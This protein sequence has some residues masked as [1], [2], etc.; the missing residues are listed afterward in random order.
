MLS[1]KL[2]NEV[3][4]PLK[5][6]IKPR[7]E[8]AVRWVGW[9]CPTGQI[10]DGTS[11]AIQ[12]WYAFGSGPNDVLNQIN[13]TG[14]TRATYIPDVQG[15][16]VASL[17]AS[18]G[19]LAKAGYQTYGESSVTS[20]TFRYTGARIDA[21]TNGLFDFRAR[22]YSPLLGRFMQ[23]DSIGAAG[24]INL[25][26]YV[27]NDPLNLID[28]FGLMPS[29]PANALAGDTS[30]GSRISGL[31]ALGL[32]ATAEGVIVTGGAAAEALFGGE[33][34][35]AG[36]FS[37][38]TAPELEA[39]ALNAARI[40]GNAAQASG[41]SSGAAGSIV[42]AEG[43]VF[44]DVSTGVASRTA[45]LNPSASQVLSEQIGTAYESK[46]AGGCAEVGCLSQLLNAGA[47][48]EG[49]VSVAVRIRGV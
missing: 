28:P 10:T 41:A 46:F 18:S 30:A 26:A 42:T 1:K 44:T 17:D 29:L 8:E 49:A 6:I 23:V 45:A 16:I 9:F 33:A 37:A 13:V 15:S 40:T 38:S 21:E 27:G 24:G 32:V 20:G 3:N 25:Y 2:R 11:G 4:S 19:T 47:N 7:P 35:L 5:S 12:N 48:P 43:T 31:Q 22:I 14:S 36:L 39:T 34:G